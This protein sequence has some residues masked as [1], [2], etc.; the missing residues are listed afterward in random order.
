MEEIYKSFEKWLEAIP[1]GKRSETLEYVRSEYKTKFETKMEIF[2]EKARDALTKEGDDLGATVNKSE[3]VVDTFLYPDDILDELVDEGSFKRA[4]CT[5]C[6]EDSSVEMYNFVSHSFSTEEMSWIFSRVPNTKLL[7]I[8]SRFGAVMY[9]AEQHHF[10]SITGI[11]I[12]PKMASLS[13]SL[14]VKSTIITGDIAKNLG[15][16]EKSDVIIFNNVFEYFMKAEQE[17][18][19]WKIIF[20]SFRPGQTLVFVPSL[21]E[22]DERLG[23]EFSNNPDIELLHAHS[24]YNIFIYR[25]INSSM[26]I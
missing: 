11:E 12:D 19:Y 20:G 6:G 9:A 26:T 2:A 25:T 3:K 17:R 15:L 13:K 23:T 8:G 22:L 10:T 14:G 16:I 21:D 18:T 7:D 24:D 5:K 1:E 4:F